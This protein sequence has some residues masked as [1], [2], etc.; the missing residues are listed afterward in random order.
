M[1]FDLEVKGST[2]IKEKII[3]E[4]SPTEEIVTAIKTASEEKAKEIM[5]VNLDSFKDKREITTAIEE[6]GTDIVRKST[7]KNSMLQTRL[8]TLSKSGGENGEVA[9]GLEELSVQMKSL[10]PSK[11]DFDNNGF[12]GKLMNPAKKYFRKYQ[13]ADATIGEIIESLDTGSRTLKN[14]NTTLEIEQASMRDLTKQLNEKIVLGMQLDAYLS[15]EIENQKVSNGDAEKIKFV[16]EEVLFPLRQRIMDFEQMLAV[17]QQG[18]LAMEVIR[19]NNAELIRSV[20]RAKT[21][22]V[23]AL[24]VA[25]MVANALCNQKLVLEKVKILNETTSD[26]IA[27]TSKMLKTQG[28]E[29]QKQAIEANIDVDKL[30]TAFADTLEA[31]DAISQ[32]KQQALPQLKETIETFRIMTED[33][34]TI[35]H[36]IEKRENTYLED[37]GLGNV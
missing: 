19:K 4:T 7:E 6:F 23:S 3:E 8:G 17:N 14:D 2:E 36:N 24:R 32:Y 12:L 1:A 29:I 15:N 34:E 18:I 28:A 16:E 11:V 37:K 30:K 9:K 35:I 5:E 22:T 27:S 10:D 21:V 13:T 33:G 31:F 20:E 26:M 25:V